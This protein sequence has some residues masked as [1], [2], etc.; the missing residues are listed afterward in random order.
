M[1]RFPRGALTGRGHQNNK[2]LKVRCYSDFRFFKLH[3]FTVLSAEPD[4]KIVS[5]GEKAKE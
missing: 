5:S 2:F 1:S 3:S 4:A